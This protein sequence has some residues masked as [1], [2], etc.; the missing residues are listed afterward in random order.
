ML[1]LGVMKFVARFLVGAVA[2]TTVMMALAG[3]ASAH[4]ELESTE[5][6]PSSV[7]LLPP[8]QVVLHFGEAVEIDFGSV[9]VIGP[10][11]K[12]VDEGNTHHPR[13][14]SHSVATALPAGLSRGTYV[15]AWRVISAD[16]HPV[17]GAFIFSVGRASSAARA[18]ALAAGI[19][20]ESGSAVVGVL[21]WLIR[22]GAYAGL[23][24]L[25]G[26]S[27]MGAIVWPAGGDVR[28]MGT[29]LWA[30]WA[31]ALFCSV[32]GIAIQGAYAASLPLIDA[33]RPSLFN[34]VLHTRFG[35][36]E[37]LRIVLL[38]CFI[39]IIGVVRGSS[40]RRSRPRSWVLIGAVLGM[41][42]LSTL[43]LSGHAGTGSDVALGM[44]LDV[45]HVAAAS[46][47]LGAMTMLGL[48]LASGNPAGT[49]VDERPPD[50]SPIALKVSACAFGAVV[51]VVAT[52][53]VQSL[54][55]VGSW[56]ALFHTVYGR[57]LVIKVL[58]VV[59]L[60]ALGGLSRRLV[61]GRWALPHLSR[62]PQMNLPLA[63]VEEPIVSPD[64][65]RTGQ[66]TI[67]PD[68][69]LIVAEHPLDGES[70]SGKRLCGLRRSVFA[71]LIIALAVLAVTALLVN[72][73]PAKQAALQPFSESFNVLG[74]QVN[75]IVDPARAGPGDQFHF[76]VLGRLGQPVGVPELDAAIS[77]PAQNV[78]P[79]SI[80]L[81]LGGPGH[82][83]AT[84]VTIP[85]AG[86]W[87][88]KVTVRT[89]A[90]DEQAVY[91]TIHVR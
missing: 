51:V 22:F 12:R 8:R 13:G 27:A 46:L 42:L 75:A 23:L 87:I 38:L 1:A 64:P 18:N 50:P 60:I 36:I 67:E 31:T 26:A 88:L 3:P 73:V 49:G 85:L 19:N 32:A 4:A 24:L 86:D 69:A 57:T 84:D 55:Q 11:G 43:G 71:E 10:D 56:Y 90:I 58:L 6:S 9:R 78:G 89:S 81:R 28:R 83:L 25:V 72:A 91:A 59:V 21:Y 62:P 76:Y 52:G 40:D 70:D 7:L 65:Q 48:L 44:S 34:E 35:E 37:V 20:G 80:P 45:G 5:P 79:L 61:H 63:L 15:V 14:D 29:L 47:W 16:S 39:P 53:V 2:A 66:A 77:L 33:L 30:S 41:C 74:V 82:Y 68:A 54:R 17:H